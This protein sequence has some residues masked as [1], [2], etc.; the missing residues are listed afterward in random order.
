[1]T[2]FL[3]DLNRI[4]LPDFSIVETTLQMILTDFQM[5]DITLPS[6]SEHTIPL[7]SFDIDVGIVKIAA[8]LVSIGSKLENMRTTYLRLVDQIEWIVAAIYYMVV[9]RKDP[10]MPILFLCG[11]DAEPVMDYL[12]RC[13]ETMKGITLSFRTVEDE[14]K[15]KE[16]VAFLDKMIR[17]VFGQSRQQ[18]DQ[19]VPNMINERRTPPAF[20]D[21]QKQKIRNLVKQS[22]VAVKTM[23]GEMISRAQKAQKQYR[24]KHKQ[25]YG[26]AYK[27]IQQVINNNDFYQEYFRLMTKH[28]TELAWT[29]LGLDMLTIIIDEYN[30][31]ITKQQGGN[32][33]KILRA[34]VDYIIRMA[35]PMFSHAT[36]RDMEVG[37]RE[38]R[39]YLFLNA[40]NIQQPAIISEALVRM[41]EELAEF[42]RYNVL[43]WSNLFNFQ[44]CVSATYGRS[45]FSGTIIPRIETFEQKTLDYFIKTPH[46][47]L[48]LKLHKK[49]L[50]QQARR[51]IQPAKYPCSLFKQKPKDGQEQQIVKKLH[52]RKSWW[53]LLVNFLMF[54]KPRQTDVRTVLRSEKQLRDALANPRLSLFY[55][56]KDLQ[57]I[58][59]QVRKILRSTNDLD[60]LFTCIDEFHG[61]M[62]DPKRCNRLDQVLVYKMPTFQNDIRMFNGEFSIREDA[63]DEQRRDFEEI[64]SVYLRLIAYITK[65]FSGELT[66]KGNYSITDLSAKL[67]ELRVLQSLIRCPDDQDLTKCLNKNNRAAKIKQQTLMRHWR[68]RHDPSRNTFQ[69]RR[70][71]DKMHEY[72]VNDISE[73]I[74]KLDRQRCEAFGYENSEKW[75]SG[76]VY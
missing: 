58:K 31:F 42:A 19:R 57:Q 38:V 15:Y 35:V 13:L 59:K 21:A 66:N 7:P 8:L 28:P 76:L 75:L 18:S 20:T 69:K 6:L 71:T 9:F 29:R 3:L 36:N 22:V 62:L 32:G 4:P 1:M 49:E 50:Q 17:S 56:Q 14:A 24:Q 12:L 43:F 53:A 23:F 33:F 67:N 52:P 61:M 55:Q 48:W 30:K 72:M 46:E 60:D 74:Y 45:T 64:R 41:R 5:V 44:I 11:G 25:T 39:P 51:R 37:L 54:W 73:I 65:C 2:V 40:V 10:D 27:D 70:L 16:L 63:T 47:E 68:N 26:K 34:V